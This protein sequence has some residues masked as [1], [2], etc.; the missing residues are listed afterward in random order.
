MTIYGEYKNGATAAFI[1]TT[2]DACG[3]NRLEITGDRGKLVL[4]DGKLKWWR[5]KTPEREFRF[6]LNDGFACHEQ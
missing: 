5:L 4:E 2:G 3:T 1:T 6:D